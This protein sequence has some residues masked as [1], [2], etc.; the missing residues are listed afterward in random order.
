VGFEGQNHNPNNRIGDQ[1]LLMMRRMEMEFDFME[2]VEVLEN[3][4]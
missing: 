4:R 2:E 1:R 3:H